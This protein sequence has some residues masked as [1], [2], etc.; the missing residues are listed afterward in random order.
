[1]K[2][3]LPFFI[4]LVFIISLSLSGCGSDVD[5]EAE[6]S[7]YFKA[8]QGNLMGTFT[9]DTCNFSMIKDYLKSWAE[10]SGIEVEH[11]DEHYVVLR[12][13][14]E[15]K[16]DKSD[17]TVLQCSVNTND[18]RG[19]LD[20]LATGLTALLGPYDHGKIRLIVTE[21]T[22]GRRIGA[23]F[24][25]EKYLKC[26]NMIAL[27]KSETNTIYTS[28]PNEKKCTLSTG[29]APESPDYDNTYVISMSMTEYADPFNFETKSNYPNPAE[30]IGGLLAGQKSAGN[31]FNI[32]S[33]TTEAHEG[34]LPYRATAVLVIDDNHVESFIK[35]FDKSFSAMEDKFDNLED[36]F[37]YTMEETEYPE[38][39]LPDNATNNLISLMYTLNTGKCYQDE[40]TGIIYSSS[41]ISS[42]STSD[43][44]LNVG[45][46]L[47][48]RGE[49][50]MDTLSKEYKLTS[51]LCSTN[52]A[53]GNT[54]MVWS[55]DPESKLAAYFTELIPIDED[56]SEIA[57][58]SFD[59]DL[60][61]K[62]IPNL[63]IITYAFNEKDCQQT[64]I[65][66]VRFIDTTV[67]VKP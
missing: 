27:Q 29:A 35:K 47:R 5:R 42:V 49:D 6:L 33:F 13:D 9:K 51:G 19:S 56:E 2:P 14:P 63:N 26:D 65:N 40:E 58:K 54:G 52:F 23:E 30:T 1:M 24:V 3:I 64:V 8:T 55:S 15:G 32:A 41:Y 39:V 46:T 20:V 12:N 25:H 53:S 44:M 43:D 59:N 50:N 28:G 61:A 45:V 22:D 18:C 16:S 37:I 48:A 67:S 4:S 10:S 34:Y 60:F 36:T 57:L 66:I 21:F 38:T 62:K 31:L 17:T 7:E 11:A